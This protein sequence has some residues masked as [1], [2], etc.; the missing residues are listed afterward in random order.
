ML[1]KLKMGVV[2]AGLF[3]CSNALASDNEEEQKPH[4]AV[5][6]AQNN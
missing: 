2:T 1:Q 5:K 6:L 4:S 3:I